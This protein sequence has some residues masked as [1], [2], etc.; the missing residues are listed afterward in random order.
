MPYFLYEVCLY[1]TTK[2]MASLIA[3]KF[4]KSDRLLDIKK[5]VTVKRYD[6]YTLLRSIDLVG[7]PKEFVE[8]EQLPVYELNKKKINKKKKK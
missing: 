1:R 8:M 2:G 4:F 7:V 3:S 5:T 6:E